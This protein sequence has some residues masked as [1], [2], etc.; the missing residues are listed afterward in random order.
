[1][2]CAHDW[3]PYR[4][5]VLGYLDLGGIFGAGGVIYLAEKAYSCDGDH[6]AEC[7]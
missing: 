1:M 4:Q 6:G 7:T 3:S 2:I 5:Q